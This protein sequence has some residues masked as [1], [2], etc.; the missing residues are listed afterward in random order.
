MFWDILCN[1]NIKRIYP[2]IQQLTFKSYKM[3][4]IKTQ[5]NC[6]LIEITQLSIPTSN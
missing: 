1:I 2:F 3:H 6:I 5:H 4:G